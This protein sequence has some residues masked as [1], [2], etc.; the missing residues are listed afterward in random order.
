M[1]FPLFQLLAI[2]GALYIVLAT[3]GFGLSRVG[4]QEG[5]RPVIPAVLIGL[6]LVQIVSW[7]FLEFTNSGLFPGVQ[8]PLSILVLCSAVSSFRRI[9]R[10]SST[11]WHLRKRLVAAYSWT[12]VLII[13]AFAYQ[14]R[15]NL[16]AGRLT[17]A[18]P[19][20]DVVAYAQVAQHIVDNGFD[21]AGRIVGANLGHIARTDVFGAYALIAFGERV[22]SLPTEQILLP[23]L[24]LAFVL[25]GHGLVGFLIKRTDL[26]GWVVGTIVALVQSLGMIGYLAGNFFLAQLIGMALVVYLA[27]AL[28]E[29][30]DGLRGDPFRNRFFSGVPMAVLLAGGIL[31]YPQMILVAPFLLLPAIL[32]R[33]SRARWVSALIRYAL[34]VAIG[35]LLVVQRIAPAIKRTLDLAGD[36]TNGWPLPGLLPSELFGLQRPA[37]TFSRQVSLVVSLTIAIVFL[38]AILRLRSRGNQQLASL[39]MRLTVLILGSYL[40]IYIRGGGPSY[41]QWKWI[42]F[43]LPL[44]FVSVFVTVVIATRLF[45]QSKVGFALGFASLSFVW[46]ITNLIRFDHFF[47]DV[48]RAAPVTVDV[49]KLGQISELKG[50]RDINV[51]AGPYLWSMWPALYLDHKTVSIVDPSYYS[52]APIT[53]APTLVNNSDTTVIHPPGTQ[54]IGSTYAL[55]PPMSGPLTTDIGSLAAKVSARVESLTPKKAQPIEI[56]YVVRNTGTAPWMNNGADVG[57]VHLGLRIYDADGS[58][59]KDATRVILSRFPGY[60]APG[61]T[62][63]GLTTVTID[64]EGDYA[65]VVTPV[66]ELVAWFN[67]LDKSFGASLEVS[68]VS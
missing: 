49:S 33:D 55:I 40:L 34:I 10:G 15:R 30:S 56:S 23:V 4:L 58:W 13:A 46:G 54:L 14:W 59:I 57:S 45:V 1:L 38:S 60:L 48:A 51:A 12:T 31:T 66:S 65:V 47:K 44:L 52:S 25:I 27:D 7:H 39:F 37:N 5:R 8:W 2:S 21:S 64:E 26:D 35:G 29:S 43:F 20:A 36:K 68:V 17:I 3:I 9:R 19:N 16:E 67:D 28:F 6:L 32:Q 61:Q 62:A 42:T 22:L 11:K 24:L 41:Q 50:V 18:S 63:Q 53:G